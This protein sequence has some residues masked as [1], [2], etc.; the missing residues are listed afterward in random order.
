MLDDSSGE[1]MEAVIDRMSGKTLSTRKLHSPITFQNQRAS[2]LWLGDYVGLR[3]RG[4]V[5]YAAF[6]DNG[7]GTSHIRFVRSP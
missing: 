7:D 6:A 2:Q 1:M 5:T 3:W 4:G